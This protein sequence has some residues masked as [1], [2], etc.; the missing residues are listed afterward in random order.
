MSELESQ[1]TEGTQVATEG[2]T[3]EHAR[4]SWLPEGFNSGEDL[5]RAY[6]DLER[7][8]GADDGTR[9]NDA[10]SPAIGTD[11]PANHSDAQALV[12]GVGLD[13]NA[14]NTEYMQNGTLSD[15]SYADLARAGI[16]REIAN[17]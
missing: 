8:H 17:G 11:V 16:S 12:D 9:A 6:A 15:Q 4:P 2:P 14:L 10:A 13:F 1:G 3:A 7:A 5:A